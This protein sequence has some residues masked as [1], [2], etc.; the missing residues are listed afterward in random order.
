[1]NDHYY[2]AVFICGLLSVQ[3]YIKLYIPGQG[4]FFSFTPPIPGSPIADLPG[5][6]FLCKGLAWASSSPWKKILPDPKDDHQVP[7]S[8]NWDKEQTR[9]QME[10][11][12]FL[13]S[14]PLVFFL[15]K[16]LELNA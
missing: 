3:I 14:T 15:N 9:D 12:T 11:K 6:P 8:S 2:E 10:W 16:T 5:K 13:D 7:F 4:G 1:M